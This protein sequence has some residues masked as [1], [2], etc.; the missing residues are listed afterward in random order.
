MAR[1]A[2]IGLALGPLGA[3]AGTIPCAI[4]GGIVGAFGAAKAGDNFERISTITSP[5]GVGYQAESKR[6]DVANKNRLSPG[7][8]NDVCLSCRA[9]ISGTITPKAITYKI[10]QILPK[11]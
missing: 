4:V 9:D 2:H 7:T 5:I 8:T 3:M 1:L 10:G 11:M 6:I